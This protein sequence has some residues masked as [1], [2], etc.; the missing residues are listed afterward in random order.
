MDGKNRDL[1]IL[2]T[3][4]DLNSHRWSTYSEVELETHLVCPT[5]DCA[6]Q[7]VYDAVVP[8]G[9]FKGLPEV[10]SGNCSTA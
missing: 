1:L 2:V 9:F 6:V 3:P 10:F 4:A 7:E 8:P 5:C